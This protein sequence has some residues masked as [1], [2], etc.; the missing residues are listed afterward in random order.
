MKDPRIQ[1]KGSTTERVLM[2]RIRVRENLCTEKPCM[3]R[4]GTAWHGNK[5]AQHGLVQSP[6]ATYHSQ[7]SLAASFQPGLL[8]QKWTPDQPQTRVITFVSLDVNSSGP[9]P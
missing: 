3:A 2:A 4:R 5:V 6:S 7:E 1:C 9:G 8:S